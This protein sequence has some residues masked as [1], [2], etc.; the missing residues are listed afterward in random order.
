MLISID[1][2]VRRAGVA[3]WEGVSLVD[4][5]QFYHEDGYLDLATVIYEY[6]EARWSEMRGIVIEKPQIYHEHSKQKGDQNDLIELAIVAGQIGAILAYG[7]DVPITYYLP[8]EWKKQMKKE[9]TTPRIQEALDEKE[10]KAILLPPAKKQQHNVW[11][12]VGIGLFHIRKKRNE[13]CGLRF[14]P[15]ISSVL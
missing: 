5:R 12:A 15:K 9:V 7:I 13:L 8:Y 14:V 2:G 4:A 3:I 10:H 11:D 1:P 6:V